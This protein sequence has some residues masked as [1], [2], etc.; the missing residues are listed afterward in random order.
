MK[1]FISI[2]CVLLLSLTL[3]AQ[4]T[5][6]TGSRS[7]TTTTQQR[8]T[9]TR[10]SSIQQRS[11]QTR[12]A[13][14]RSSSRGTA[15]TT[16]SFSKLLQDA[17]SNTRNVNGNVN[18][19]ASSHTVS[20]TSQNKTSDIESTIPTEIILS[21]NSEVGDIDVNEFLS[22]FGVTKYADMTESDTTEDVQPQTN[23]VSDHE[24]SLVVSGEGQTKNEATASALR[25]AIEQ[26][27]GTFVSANT[28]LLNDDIVRDEIATVAS[29]NIKSYKELS[30]F[31]NENGHYNVSVSAVVSIGKLISYAQ[32]HGSSAEF[33][34]QTLAMNAKMW[35][36]NKKN[37]KE[38]LLNMVD[39]LHALQDNLFDYKIT[40][41]EASFDKN[42]NNYLVPIVL[43]LTVN[44][45]F[46]NFM[47]ILRQTL[48]FLS[49]DSSDN[50]LNMPFN[51]FFL[52]ELINNDGKYGSIMIDK[53]LTPP[54]KLRSELEFLVWINGSICKILR[55]AQKSVI[56]RTR[57][58]QTIEWR[59][60]DDDIVDIYATEYSPYYY[61]YTPYNYTYMGLKRG[62][63]R[64]NSYSKSYYPKDGTLYDI[65]GHKID[66]MKDGFGEKRSC[67]LPKSA[68]AFFCEIPFSFSVN[69][70]SLAGIEG[71][72]VILPSSPSFSKSNNIKEWPDENEIS[73]FFF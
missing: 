42:T 58:S 26:A 49:F 43:T 18:T 35:E 7:R 48:S 38:A 30:C 52:D 16:S 45:N 12:S 24:I 65:E 72:D 46:E 15:G 33:A 70:E 66:G 60:S 69:L 10:N 50:I 63:R 41:N 14:T 21:N 28:T 57:G 17:V 34:G 44:K 64:Y 73:E 9:Q 59:P 4:N 31:Q 2:V 55:D 71:F 37:E 68:P 25:S 27:F 19:R 39:Q 22:A 3:F 23:D 47:S 1:R 67:M 5:R 61:T 8:S 6:N 11:S 56:V 40:V 32:S 53:S 62:I 13:Q 20:S 29:G 51:Y 36:L 54:Y